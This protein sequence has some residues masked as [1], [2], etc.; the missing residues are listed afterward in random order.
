VI[1]INP[2]DLS[3]PYIT[4]LGVIRFLDA[5]NVHLDALFIAL[6]K[7]VLVVEII[8]DR[9]KVDSPEA[10]QNFLTSLGE[11][12]R[13]DPSK[14]AALE[15]L[16]DFQG[17]FWCETDERVREIMSKFEREV[18]AAAGGN[19]HL[20]GVGAVAAEIGQVRRETNEDW[21]QHTDR[22]QRLVNETQLARLNQMIKV[23]DEDI[24]D[25][26]HF[27][28]VVI[29]DLDR[30]WVDERVANDLVRCLF[31]AVLDMKRVT[32]LKIVVA[33]RTNIFDQ[34][35]FGSRS[36]AQEEKYRS[37]ALHLR[38]TRMDLTE[39]LSERVRIASDM[40]RV[41]GFS[42]IHGLLP[43]ATKTRD[44]LAFVLNRTLMRPRDAIAY[45]NEAVREGVDRKRLTWDHLKAVETTYSHKRLLAL[46]DEWKGSYPDIEKVLRLFDRRAVPITRDE[47]TSVLDEAI[48][49][50]SD[51]AFQ[52][53]TWMLEL[54][55]GAWGGGPT[56]DWFDLYQ[57]LT[58]LLYR[59]GFIGCARFKGA[60]E[61]YAYDDMEFPERAS[62]LGPEAL[63]YVHRAFRATL[64]ITNEP[65]RVNGTNGSE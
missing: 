42:D 45:V 43:A 46:R 18:T 31:R 58:R 22:F 63:F 37:L 21:S 26:Q 24:L 48:L 55:Q 6:W 39:M 59:I 65:R 51:E 17:R 60:P 28:Y 35:H 41:P 1:R 64:D 4:D 11:R 36:S 13:R 16:N 61:T 25:E 2:E 33:L 19:L 47:F 56:D 40:F 62:N 14:Q 54:G 57:P 23:L 10:K 44:P 50:L 29:D 52:G 7:H 8:R 27:T 38:W 49:L 53:K 20:P 15:Y 3:L 34:L 9:Y 32:N 30:D 12:I 5:L